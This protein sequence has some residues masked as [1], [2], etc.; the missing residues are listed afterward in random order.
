MASSVHWINLIAYD[1]HST[2]K[3]T[4]HA[5]SDIISLDAALGAFGKEGVPTT[6]INLGVGFFGRSYELSDTSSCPGIGCPATRVGTA[7]Q[8]T[9]TPGFLSY[10][11][12][13]QK[14]GKTASK[15]DDKTATNYL[16]YDDDQ[17]ISFENGDFIIQK[18][19]YAETKGLLGLAVWAINMD[20]G[21]NTL[22]NATL[23][24]VGLGKFSLTTGT[25]Q[26]DSSNCTN[27]EN[28]ACAWSDCKPHSPPC[29][30]GQQI[31]TTDRC[32]V[33]P[34]TGEKR[35]KALCCPLGQTTDPRICDWNQFDGGYCVRGCKSG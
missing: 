12:I 24:P 18:V 22:L 31:L 23:Y 6:Q 27:V 1:E 8:C 11:E 4:T 5:M 35:Y 13:P 15:Y 2:D 30:A 17:W 29:P 10:D 21:A 32:S 33:A 19:K 28:S 14:F 7:G 25:G 3:S 16:S 9:D 26:S 20:D 34:G